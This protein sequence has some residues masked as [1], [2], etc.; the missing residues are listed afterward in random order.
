M[1]NRRARVQ[2]VLPAVSECCVCNEQAETRCR[3]LD[4]GGRFVCDACAGPLVDAEDFLR[5]ICQLASPDD[6][7]IEEHLR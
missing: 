5:V 7:L 4:F 6:A 1:M 2:L 3:D